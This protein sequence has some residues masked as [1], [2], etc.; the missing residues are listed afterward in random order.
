MVEV[1]VVIFRSGNQ[2]FFAVEVIENI[3]Q[4]FLVGDPECEARNFEFRI[5]S[6]ENI[7]L[8]VEIDPG[9]FQGFSLG[10]TVK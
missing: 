4:F 10:G 6:I 7:H 8:L 1:I 5:L 3:E 2:A 9:I